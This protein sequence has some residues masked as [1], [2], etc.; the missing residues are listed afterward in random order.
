MKAAYLMKTAHLM[1][2]AGAV[3]GAILVLS[4][5]LAAE[6]EVHTDNG[7]SYVSGGVGDD[8]RKALQAMNARFDLKITMALESGNFVSDVGVRIR[9]SEGRTVL[10]TVA[11]GPLLLAQLQSGTYSVTCTLNGKALKQTVRI[12]T[13]SQRQLVFRWKSE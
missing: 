6:L 12:T 1:K 10:E 5:V 7:V 9:D 11:D 4:P 3:L 2:H 8:E 13:G